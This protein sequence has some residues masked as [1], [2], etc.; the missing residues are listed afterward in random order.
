M[1]SLVLI[2]ITMMTAPPLLAASPN[3]VTNSQ[4]ESFSIHEVEN[5]KAYHG[6]KE[7]H[8]KNSFS[9]D[10]E[11][12]VGPQK[13]APTFTWIVSFNQV[14]RKQT[15]D[16]IRSYDLSP[17]CYIPN[18]SY[19]VKGTRL[20]MMRLARLNQVSQY[21]KYKPEMKIA[22]DV[23]S[24]F[25]QYSDDTIALDIWVADHARKNFVAD[26]ISQ[27]GSEVINRFAGKNLITAWVNRKQLQKI[28]DD[29]DVAWVDV[30]P[31][32]EEDMNNAKIVTAVDQLLKIDVETQQY[33]GIGIIGHV[34]EGI[35]PDHQ[36]FA[37]NDF[38][39]K[40][41]SI[42][43]GDYSSHG[44]RTYGIVFGSG[45][46]DENARGYLPNAQGYYTN[47]SAVS[48]VNP[49]ESETDGRYGLVKSLIKEQNIMFQTASWG[50]STTT[51]YTAR[52]AEMDNIIFDLDIPITQSQSNTGSKL[53][54][55]QAWAKNIIS[56]GGVV[57]IN[58]TD[59]N[60]DH[61]KGSASIGPAAD[62]RIKPD[63]VGFYDRI[64][65]TS[66]NGYTDFGGT[67]GATPMIAGLVGLTIEMWTNGVFR[68]EL[69]LEPTITNR[70]ENRPRFTTVKAL[71]INTARRYDFEGPDHDLTRVH[72][73]WGMPQMSHLY[74]A[75]E[76]I[77]IVNEEIVMKVN[78]FVEYSKFWEN[79]EGL[80]VTLTWS[81]PPAL[82]SLTKTLVN[83]LDL[84]VTS[85]SGEVYHGNYGLMESNE[86]LAGG[87]PDS[88]NT[89][90]NVFLTS[91]EN[92][93]WKIRVRSDRIAQDGLPETAELDTD[94]A[95]VIRPIFGD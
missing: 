5:R 86:S 92:G 53:S 39:K 23:T 90:E 70:F 60:D 20:Q 44:Q 78:Q 61:W 17:I 8:L 67:S 95:L 56:V 27:L 87:T 28:V 47:T 12:N 26:R 94:F 46:G 64:R 32:V 72:Q 14:I 18:N 66:E 33:T 10:D 1:H 31:Q 50:Y 15:L 49:G 42:L 13:D 19:L 3:T 35:N 55:P 11:V 25:G 57:H 37:A 68:N 9:S 59:P 69:A 81:D 88:I 16:I 91:P 24:I 30:T 45:V 4:G 40:P 48:G 73:G 75:R 2:V 6:K 52:S 62:G 85:P 77:T 82:P 80:A 76:S 29:V 7:V 22:S 84:S 83:N 63:L 65:T 58:N 34:L 38:R 51:K 71:L 79:L 74:N 21:K 36:D 54:R 93:Q 41:I 89:V 43:N